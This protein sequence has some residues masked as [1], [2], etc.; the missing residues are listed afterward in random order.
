MNDTTINSNL[1]PDEVLLQTIPARETI[2]TQSKKTAQLA[3]P[4]P[5]PTPARCIRALHPHYQHVRFYIGSPA[6]TII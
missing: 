1:F 3:K 2:K 5:H 6:G 4:T